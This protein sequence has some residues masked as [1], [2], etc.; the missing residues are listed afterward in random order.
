LE[1]K[2]F[3]E[4]K[5]VFAIAILLFIWAFF[6][7]FF[8]PELLFL[9]TTTAG[10]DTASHYYTAQYLKE[11]LLPQGKIMGWLPANYAGFPI[12]YHYFPFTFLLM[13]FLGFILPL[14]ISF[15]LV[16]VLGTFLL[17]LAVYLMFR[18]LKYG[19]PVPVLGRQH[20]QHPG[21]R[22]LFFLQP[23][24]IRGPA[25]HIVRG[26]FQEQIRYP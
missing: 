20:P 24:A 17:P 2:R 25:G 14:E 8:K 3:L 15:K 1:I 26:H 16:T 7:T 9:K 22:V 18:T 5:T 23:G 11:V 10:G 13:V 12:F 19:F 21:R 4:D 6:L